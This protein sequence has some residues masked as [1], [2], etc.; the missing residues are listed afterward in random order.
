VID[1]REL[2]PEITTP[3]AVGHARRLVASF[4]AGE[5]DFALLLA[6][7]DVEVTAGLVCLLSVAAPALAFDSTQEWSPADVLQLLEDAV[8]EEL[9]RSAEEDP[10]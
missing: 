9:R 10:T 5:T 4:L 1:I 7:S 8:I 2:N 6:E 3:G